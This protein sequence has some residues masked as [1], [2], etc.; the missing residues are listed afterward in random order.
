MLEVEYTDEGHYN[1]YTMSERR[2]SLACCFDP[3]SPRLTAF[4]IHEWIHSQLQ[5]SEHSVLMIQIDGTRRQVFIKFT[6]FHFVQDILNA[7]NGETVYKHT[8]GEISPVKLMVAGMGPRRIRLANLP[9][10][11]TTLP[12]GWLSPT[13]ETFNQYKTKPG[14]NIIVTLSQMAYE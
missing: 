13:M 1:G 12:Y 9:Q 6:D 5:V 10:N 4:N 14:Q 3:T 2:N 8:T 11:Y 7:T